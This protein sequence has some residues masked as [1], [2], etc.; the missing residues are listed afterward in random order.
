MANSDNFK[1]KN[2]QGALSLFVNRSAY[3]L[4]AYS[5]DDGFVRPFAAT[6]PKLTYPIR[7]FRVYENFYYGRVDPFLTPVTP[8]KNKLTSLD[9][10]IVVFDFVRDAFLAM[11]QEINFTKTRGR[12]PEDNPHIANMEPMKAFTD[13][14]VPYNTYLN[15]V[16]QKFYWYIRDNSE[17]QLGKEITSFETFAPIFTKFLE[18]YATQRTISQGAFLLTSFYGSVNNSGLVVE[19]ADFDK[20]DD[21][22]KYEFINNKCF[23][24]YVKLASKYGFY[25][26][27]NA[28]W[29]LIAD[30]TSP[31][32]LKFREFRGAGGNLSVFFKN[33]Y[34]PTYYKETRVIKNL[35]FKVYNDLVEARP[36]FKTD[37]WNNSCRYSKVVRRAP[38]THRIFSSEYDNGYWLKKY[39]KIKNWESGKVIQRQQLHR[40]IKNS[41]DLEKRVDNITALRYINN[42]FRKMVATAKGSFNDALYVAQYKDLE[43]LPFD[44]LQSLI[45]EIYC[46]KIGNF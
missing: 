15:S 1:G 37:A 24:Y 27:Y 6:N 12:L 8:N 18:Q 32:M 39:I 43:E 14:N 3:R 41:Q 17:L 22:T 23:P 21:S 35:Y 16:Q 45:D 33:Y 7:N 31:P 11:K 2:D 30:I 40:I 26:D 46:F 9:T 38:K 20:S 19:I 36:S 29:R 42:K 10:G 13:I 44:N 25:I 4:F 5:P 34:T 28:P